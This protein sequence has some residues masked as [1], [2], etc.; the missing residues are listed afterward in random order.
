MGYKIDFLSL[1]VYVSEIA[2]PD[3]RGCLSGLLKVVGHAGVLLSFIGGAY[4][5]FR[6]LALV[7]A[8]APVALFIGVLYVP[9]TPSYLVLAG[10]DDEAARA[11]RWLRGPTADVATE[12]A[13][14]RANVRRLKVRKASSM[15]HAAMIRPALTTCGLMLFQRFSGANSFQFYAVSIF[16]Q[17][18]GGKTFLLANCLAKTKNP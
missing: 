6:Q 7:V 18:L 14:L 17:T 10:K 12:L 16:R 13:V 3:V 2:G 11:L 4:L 1:Q 5:D 8:A 15:E 9:E